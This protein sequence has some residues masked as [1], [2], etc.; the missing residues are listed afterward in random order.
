MNKL[1]LLSIVFIFGCAIKTIEK[2]SIPNINKE[3][4]EDDQ[5]NVNSKQAKFIPFDIAPKVISPIKPIYPKIAQQKGIQ[6]TIIV[7]F[8]IDEEGK[9]MEA[10]VV[11][12][13]PD[14]GLND[15]AIACV[16]KSIWKPAQQRDWSGF[17]TKNVGAW[18]TIP[19]KFELTSN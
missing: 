6:G 9:V 10:Y 3:K 11:E 14:S 15:A 7:S 13:I 17:R 5:S 4:V 1:I 8:F 2:N 12:G 19:I 18:Q 16:K